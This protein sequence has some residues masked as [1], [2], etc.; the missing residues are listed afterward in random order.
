MKKFLSFF[1]AVAL[2]S[3]MVCGFTACNSNSDDDDDDDIE[4]SESEA[5]GKGKDRDEIKSN[6]SDIVGD[7]QWVENCRNGDCESVDKYEGITL[8]SDGTFSDWRKG[9]EGTWKLKGKT[10]K[11]KYDGH[12]KTIKYKIVE[13]DDDELVLQREGSHR[14]MRCVRRY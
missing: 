3:A 5:V 6:E 9:D 10:L 13:L 11:L 4:S 1:A 12:D 7:W 14:T 8:S 2:A